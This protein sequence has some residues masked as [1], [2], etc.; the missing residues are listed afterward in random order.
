MEAFQQKFFESID[1]KETISKSIAFLQQKQLFDPL[2]EAIRNTSMSCFNSIYQE[3]VKNVGQ[4]L[5]S[6]DEDIDH[7]WSKRI[8]LFSNNL[9]GILETIVENSRTEFFNR[10]KLKEKPRVYQTYDNG[11]REVIDG[12]S[13]GKPS[14]FIIESSKKKSC[15]PLYN[16]Q[17]GPVNSSLED[18]KGSRNLATEISLKAY[19]SSTKKLHMRHGSINSYISNSPSS[20]GKSTEKN[21][22]NFMTQP[23]NIMK[24]LSKERKSRPQSKNRVKKY[25]ERATK[26]SPRNWIKK[27]SE[28]GLSIKPGSGKVKQKLVTSRCERKKGIESIASRLSLV[29]SAKRLKNS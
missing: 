20:F 8:T 14:N 11:P 19:P 6:L 28:A 17:T 16:F 26:L 15:S 9:V 27:N 23:K 12:G 29:S 13:F 4:N 1:K 5:D 25:Y 22:R 24:T 3:E 7:S 21:S 18:S 10:K 2:I